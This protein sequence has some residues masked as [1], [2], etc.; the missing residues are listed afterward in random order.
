MAENT[1]RQPGETRDYKERFEFRF[2]VGG[3]IICQ[4]YFRIN[5]FNPLS[6]Y[7]LELVQT[8]RDC[9]KMIDSDLK[10]KTERYLYV[11][12]PQVFN[13]EEEMFKYYKDEKN[14]KNIRMG[15]GIVIRDPKAPNYVWGKNDCPV[16]LAEKFD[17]DGEFTT[18]ITDEDV[19]TYKFAFYDD[20]REVCATTWEGVYPKY[21]RNSIDLSNKRGKLP[22]GED[23]SKLGFE[24]YLLYKLVEGK[25]D[26]VYKIIKDICFTCSSQDNSWYTTTT[27]FKKPDGS[28][29]K[30]DN[31]EIMKETRKELKRMES[32]LNE[33]VG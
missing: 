25:S 14:R 19:V 16:A 20:G 8:I 23:P 17:K 22:E 24:A 7:S 33:Q 5:N 9:G 28:I 18:P 13:T 21:I 11:S 27:S 10:D 3:N 6:L 15:H 30:Y 2:T 31:S 26:I 29:V 4:R 12:A 32:Y 1:R